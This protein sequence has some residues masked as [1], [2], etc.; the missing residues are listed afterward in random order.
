MDVDK[1]IRDKIAQAKLYLH[2]DHSHIGS[3]T[4]P[5]AFVISNDKHRF[6]SVVLTTGGLPESDAEKRS[7]LDTRF[8][9]VEAMLKDV[10][11]KFGA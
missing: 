1:Y 6:E 8:G 5:S 11:K 2:E 7:V 9:N 10:L 4:R 3:D